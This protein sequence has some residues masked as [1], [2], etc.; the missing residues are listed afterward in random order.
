SAALEAAAALDRPDARERA[1]AALARIL[2]EAWD[3]QRGIAHRVGDDGPSVWGLL[4]DQAQLLAA[5]VEAH[6][7]TGAARWLE[8]ARRLSA[9]LRRDWADPRGGYADMATW[10][11]AD[12]PVEVLAE[13]DR[14]VADAP[15]PGANAVAAAAHARLHLL[16]GDPAE[17]EAAEGILAAFAHESRR[18]G[19]FAATYLLALDAALDPPPHV[20]VVAAPGDARGDALAKAALAPYAPGRVVVRLEPGASGEGIP[21]AAR[22][23]LAHAGAGPLAFVCHGTSCS[24]PTA[25]PGALARLVGKG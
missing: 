16:T 2:D 3:E 10:A 13:P 25:D 9:L 20:T 1:L 19:V 11:R 8:V 22:G 12:V 23:M 18:Q 21:A 15:T 6:V 17:R 4:D 5:L 24:A 7:Q 14:P